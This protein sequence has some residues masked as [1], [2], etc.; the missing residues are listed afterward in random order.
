MSE[1]DGES[2][3]AIDSASIPQADDLDKI[4]SVVASVATGAGTSAQ[5]AEQ[6]GFSLRHS[7][8]RISAAE[9]LG[10]LARR[11]AKIELTAPARLLL[12]TEQQSERERTAW[13]KLISKTELAVLVPDLFEPTTPDKHDLATKLARATGMSMSTAERRAGTLLSWRRRLA[14]RQLSLFDDVYL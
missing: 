3:G 2:V 1:Q 9:V 10:L 14:S 11:D 13:L 5:I 7:E 8:Y 6:T 4:R 12:A